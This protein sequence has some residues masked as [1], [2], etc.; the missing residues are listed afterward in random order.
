MR[1]LLVL[2]LVLGMASLANAVVVY[3][4]TGGANTATGTINVYVVGATADVYL[5]LVIESPGVVSPN[6]SADMSLGAAAPTMSMYVQEQTVSGDSGETWMFGA[7]PGESYVD[8]IWLTANWTG[9]TSVVNIKLYDTPD[10]VTFTLLDT[11]PVGV[12]EPMTIALLGLGGLLLRR[13]R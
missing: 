1:K 12:P 3:D 10:G 13:R 7:A 9:A 4:L 11:Q 2:T 5:A 8:G 6:A